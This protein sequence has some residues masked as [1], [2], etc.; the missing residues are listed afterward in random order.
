MRAEGIGLTD[1]FK[2]YIV[3]F[4]VLIFRCYLLLFRT[5]KVAA[6]IVESHSIKPTT[7][8]PSPSTS[9]TPAATAAATRAAGITAAAAI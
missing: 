5:I 6:S 7:S 8:S 1:Q 2:I 9:F 3:D 4:S